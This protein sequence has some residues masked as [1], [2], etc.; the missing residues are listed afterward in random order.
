MIHRVPTVVLDQQLLC[1]RGKSINAEHPAGC[2][3]LPK[4]AHAPRGDISHAGFSC[5]CAGLGSASLKS[6]CVGRGLGR[7]RQ[8]SLDLAYC[9]G[10][11]RR[12][13]N[14]VG[15]TVL[16]LLSHRNWEMQPNL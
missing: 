8:V 10:C 14:V 12:E 5:P 1:S 7:G 4:A 6:G 3:S 9:W 13:K 16:L 11:G 15:M 2:W